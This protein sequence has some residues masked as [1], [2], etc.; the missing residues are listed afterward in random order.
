M[1]PN[2][3]SAWSTRISGALLLLL[4][5]LSTACL[6]SPRNK[7]EVSPNNFVVSGLVPT[8]GAIVHVDAQFPDRW[9]ELVE[10]KPKGGASEQTLHP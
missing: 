1:R 4:G 7:Q 8:P 6:S 5:L 3:S 10:K 2:R 9:S